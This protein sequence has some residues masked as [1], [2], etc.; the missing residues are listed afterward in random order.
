MKT[1]ESIFSIVASAA[2]LVTV[3][4]L[5]VSV[6]ELK[7]DVKHA[8]ESTQATMESSA[9]VTVAKELT[10]KLW[11]I[12]EKEAEIYLESGNLE[13]LLEGIDEGFEQYRRSHE[14]F[15]D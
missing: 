12:T 3:I 7:R 13:K 8:I 4:L 10:A 14:L 1:V 11:E 15:G 5:W 6:L 2:I 9:T